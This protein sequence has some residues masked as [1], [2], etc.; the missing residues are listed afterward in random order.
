MSDGYVEKLTIESV[1]FRVPQEYAALVVYVGNYTKG[2]VHVYTIKPD[3]FDMPDERIATVPPVKKVVN[4]KEVYVSV[5]PRLPAG[6]Y[7]VSNLHNKKTITLFSGFISEVD[8]S[9]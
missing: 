3:Y 4:G 7:H 6:T 1:V 5:F 8:L 9:S 2:N